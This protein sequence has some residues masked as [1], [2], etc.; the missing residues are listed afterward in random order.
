MA[1]GYFLFSRAPFMLSSAIFSVLCFRLLGVGLCCSQPLYGWALQFGCIWKECIWLH[2]VQMIFYEPPHLKFILSVRSLMSSSSVFEAFSEC[3]IV[4]YL[5]NMNDNHDRSLIHSS[6]K[7]DVIVRP[8]VL[9]FSKWALNTNQYVIISMNDRTKYH[10]I[11]ND[12]VLASSSV[13]FTEIQMYHTYR[14]T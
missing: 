9:I 14:M 7:L 10:L 3:C 1:N 6:D 13:S 5:E 4:T 11:H 12:T 8:L 2:L